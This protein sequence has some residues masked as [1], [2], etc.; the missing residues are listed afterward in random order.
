M[1]IL[2]WAAK[3]DQKHILRLNLLSTLLDEA[4]QYMH[5][6]LCASVHMCKL[7]LQVHHTILEP[8]KSRATAVGITLHQSPKWNALSPYELYFPC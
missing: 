2:Y 5:N 1:L 6:T 8:E 7:F 3:G 4:F